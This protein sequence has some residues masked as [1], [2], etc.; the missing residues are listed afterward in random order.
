MAITPRCDMCEKELIDFGALLFSPPD[1]T[2]I[3]KKYHICKPCYAD[4]I[5]TFKS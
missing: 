2:N 5:K 3:V 1:P 4:L